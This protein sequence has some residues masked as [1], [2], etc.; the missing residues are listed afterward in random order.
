VTSTNG[1]DWQDGRGEGPSLAEVLYVLQGRRLLVVGVVLV[2]AGTALLFG[3]FR[4]PVYTAEAAVRVEP[5][6][7]LND[8][9]VGEAFMQEVQ[10]DVVTEEMLRKV[11]DRAGWEAGAAEFSERLDP[12]T[13]ANRDGELGMLVRFSATEPGQAAR[14][15]NAYAE[16]FVEGVGRLDEERLA[17]GTP[18]RASVE[19]RAMPG[20]FSPRPL[21]YAAVAAGAGL[22]LGGAAALLL[23]GRASGWRGVRDAEL[24]LGAPVLGTIPDYSSASPEVEG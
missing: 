21:V 20:G 24:T 23:E 11:R 5:Q 2:L 15:A 7:G 14:A 18:V 17:G 9:E 19:Q 12:Q 3:L 22:L 10:G 1:Q 6:G 8:E 16:L 4:E 13:F